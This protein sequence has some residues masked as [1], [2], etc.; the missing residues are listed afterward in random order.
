MLPPRQA[1]GA[2]G[3]FVG[4]PP[5]L[6][7]RPSCGDHEKAGGNLIGLDRLRTPLRSRDWL[8]FFSDS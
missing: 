8:L 7:A 2:R 1:Q 3:P 4:E 6:G 5:I